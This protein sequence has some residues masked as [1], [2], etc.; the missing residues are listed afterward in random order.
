M[1]IKRRLLLI[2]IGTAAI[3]GCVGDDDDQDDDELA[4]DDDLPEDGDDEPDDDDIEDPDDGE[5]ELEPANTVEITE[6]E[7]Y[8]EI[9]VDGNGLTLYMF[10]EDEQGAGESACYED[11]ASNW[12][13]LTVDEE[14]I[15]GEDVVAQLTT[16]ERD[17]EE[18]S[19]QV[20]ADG[21]PLYYWGGDEEPGDVNG[22]G[23][24]DVWWVLDMDGTPIRDEEDEEPDNGEDDD[25]EADTPDDEEDDGYDEDEEDDEYED[26]TPD[27]DGGDYGY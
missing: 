21:W 15:A 20:A 6:H 4:T 2:G 23:V 24:Q 3:A 26:D 18:E 22:Q 5:E 25:Y 7:E 9:L 27:D 14:A 19:L 12:P 10:D 16:F 11:C 8:G 17:D 13:P 1:S